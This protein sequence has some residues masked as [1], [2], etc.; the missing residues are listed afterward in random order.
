MF[1][2]KIT[3]SLLLFEG[4]IIGSPLR[5][6]V[7]CQTFFKSSIHKVLLFFSSAFVQINQRFPGRYIR[8]WWWFYKVLHFFPHRCTSNVVLYG[9]CSIFVSLNMGQHKV[10]CICMYCSRE[11]WQVSTITTFSAPKIMTVISDTGNV[12]SVYS[13]LQSAKERWSMPW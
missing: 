11:T 12:C 10:Q 3:S 4:L 5:N 1:Q 6:L 9:Q 13:N 7:F 8:W 2:D